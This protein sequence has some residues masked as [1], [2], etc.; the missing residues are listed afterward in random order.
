MPDD[1]SNDEPSAEDLAD[2]AF[3]RK[4]LRWFGPLTAALVGL[5]VGLYGAVV[6]G[7]VFGLLV[8]AATAALVGVTMWFTVRQWP[9]ERQG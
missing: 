3:L 5:L 7:L 6:R 9:Q 1:G 8:G 2:F 4:R